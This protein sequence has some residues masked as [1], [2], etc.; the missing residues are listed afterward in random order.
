MSVCV[1]A[2]GVA[3]PSSGQKLNCF[4]CHRPYASKAKADS[5]LAQEGEAY[6]KEQGDLFIP[7]VA[8]KF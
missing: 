3:Q 1:C 7:T 6:K 4:V 8:W 2:Y 5:P